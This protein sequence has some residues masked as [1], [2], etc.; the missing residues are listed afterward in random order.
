V[1]NPQPRGLSQRRKFLIGATPF[2]LTVPGRTALGAAHVCTPS[3]FM[4]LSPSHT[5][6]PADLNC[7]LSYLCW[8]N[9][10]AP[11]WSDKYLGLSVTPSTP[12]TGADAFNLTPNPIGPIDGQQQFGFS[13]TPTNGSLQS[14]LLG[15]L[16]LTYTDGDKNQHTINPLFV[17]KITA[18]LLNAL[19]FNNGTPIND[20]YPV[21]VAFVKSEVGGFWQLA[22]KSVKKDLLTIAQINAAA[23]TVISRTYIV[24]EQFCDV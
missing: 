14:G 16:T 24:S 6:S 13:L 22:N 2:I 7:G 11:Y 20:H 8:Q 23:D 3:G 10:A 5:A 4:S 9:T 18:A 21:S 17:A 1:E 15:G 19:A 12:F